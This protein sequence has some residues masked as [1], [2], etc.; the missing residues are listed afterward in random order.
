MNYVRLFVLR[1]QIAQLDQVLQR[2][3]STPEKRY[4][5]SG[6]SA[7][8]YNAEPADPIQKCKYIVTVPSIRHLIIIFIT[9]IVKDSQPVDA[10]VWEDPSHSKRVSS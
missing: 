6:E 8:T 10:I 1:R 5:L 9:V 4:S 7:D 2:T 3:S